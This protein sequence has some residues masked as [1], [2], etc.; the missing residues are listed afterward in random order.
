MTVRT[1]KWV[2]MNNGH[3]CGVCKEN[4]YVVYNYSLLWL[5]I[6]HPDRSP[7]IVVWLGQFFNRG[8][9][10]LYGN[11]CRKKKYWTIFNKSITHCSYWIILFSWWNVIGFTHCF[12]SVCI[13]CILFVHIEI[14]K[15]MEVIVISLVFHFLVFF[16][17]CRSLAVYN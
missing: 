15:V 2:P 1:C 16:F 9:M 4:I 17:F 12:P 7:G 13:Q 3:W 8:R 6:W 10:L 5:E 11:S 14:I